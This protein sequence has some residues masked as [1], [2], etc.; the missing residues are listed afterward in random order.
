LGLFFKLILPDKIVE[1]RW[2]NLQVGY[3]IFLCFFRRKDVFLHSPEFV[4]KP[5]QYL[6]LVAAAGA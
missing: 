5:Y 6:W 3:L 4:I 1:C 2:S